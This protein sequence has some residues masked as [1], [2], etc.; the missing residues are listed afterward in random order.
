M[1]EKIPE[2]SSKFLEVECPKCKKTSIVFNKAATRVKCD[3]CNE[4]IALPTGGIATI[5]GKVVKELD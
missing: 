2:P 4:D 5:L 3:G 1:K